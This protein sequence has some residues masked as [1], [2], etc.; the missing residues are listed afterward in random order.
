MNSLYRSHRLLLVPS[1]VQDA[2]LRVI[3][4]A[5]LHGTP[6]IGTDRGGIPEAEVSSRKR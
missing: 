4:E 6:G 3:V 2:F 1:T 5:A